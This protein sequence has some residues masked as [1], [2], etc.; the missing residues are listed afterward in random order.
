MVLGNINNAL[1]YLCKSKVC[2][3]KVKISLA[4]YD[5]HVRFFLKLTSHYFVIFVIKCAYGI[6][7]ARYSE[8][9]FITALSTFNVALV[10]KFDFFTHSIIAMIIYIGLKINICFVYFTNFPTSTTADNDI[11]H[12]LHHILTL[13]FHSALFFKISKACF[14]FAAISFLRS[15]RKS[16]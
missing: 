6:F 11:F 13:A 4:I 15:I 2:V 16:S 5:S 8:G 3:I 14:I 9:D 12:E 10:I 7:I 1:L